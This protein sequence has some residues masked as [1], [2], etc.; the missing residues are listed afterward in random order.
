MK[1]RLCDVNPAALGKLPAL[2]EDKSG[3]GAHYV[4]AYVKPMNR[5]L[6]DGTP[7]KCK[8][9]RAGTSGTERRIQRRVPDG[10]S[11]RLPK[12][13]EQRVADR[14]AELFRI[15]HGRRD[16][17]DR[18]TLWGAHDGMSWKNNYPVPRPHELC[19]PVRP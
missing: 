2:T 4:D 7:V 5:K 8:R 15:F 14:W 9:G 18:V 6:E 10:R 16:K 11:R 13:V 17:I 19:A 1:V 3:I 12:D